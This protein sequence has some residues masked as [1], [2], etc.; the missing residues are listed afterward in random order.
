M[1]GLRFV[2]GFMYMVQGSRDVS[3]IYLCKDCVKL[4]LEMCRTVCVC[5]HI[6]DLIK[7]ADLSYI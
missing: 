1:L 7:S 4:H 5:F 2:Y 3:C 6:N